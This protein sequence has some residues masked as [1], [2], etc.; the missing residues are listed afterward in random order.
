LDNK[1]LL[2]INPNS[3]DG[4]AKHWMFDMVS[5][6]SEKYRYITTYLSKGR[7]DIISTL[8][9]CSGEYDAVVCCGGDGTL[10]EVLNG[11]VRSGRDIPIGYIPT[12]TIN[13]FAFSHGI[14]LNAVQCIENIKNGKASKY[15]YGMI[16][17]KAFTYVAAFGSF[18]DVC[19][20][21]SQD[22][23][24]MF[25]IVAYVTEA[26]KKLSSLKSYKVKVQ[27][28]SETI[29]EELVCGLVSNSKSIAGIKIFRNSDPNLLRDG[30]MDV[31]LIKYPKSIAE[32]GEAVTAFIAS[33]ESPLIYRTKAKN[34]TFSFEGDVP[35]WTTDGEFGGSAQKMN[36]HIVPQGISL[37]ENNPDK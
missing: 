13:D 4:D 1:L 23:K 33:A 9:E 11:L 32:F 19:Y 22:A 34:V 6:F 10:H 17:D 5:A 37:L 7:G 31:T 8:S 35:E 20:K 2:I 3:G 15:D 14:P 24:A 30:M 26:I 27:T 25:G 16:E 12:G 28:E 18:I 29:E 21:T 36:L